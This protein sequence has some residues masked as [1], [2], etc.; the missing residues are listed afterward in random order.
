MAMTGT[1]LAAARKSALDAISSP[2]SSNPADATAYRDALL[3]ADSTAIVTYI[4]GNGQATG[5][6]SRG[7]S[8]TLAIN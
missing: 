3:I 7:D 5:S 2:S 4:Q 6:D 8:H 1:G